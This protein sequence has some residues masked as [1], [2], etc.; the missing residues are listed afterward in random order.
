MHVESLPPALFPQF[1]SGPLSYH[2]QAIEAMQAM[3]AAAGFQAVRHIV[4]DVMNAALVGKGRYEAR[5]SL[6]PQSYVWAFAGTSD[7]AAGFKVQIVDL[8][9]KAE[10]FSQPIRWDNLTGQGATPEGLSFPLYIL[11]KPRLVLEPGLLSVQVTNL[12]AVANPIQLVVFTAE[13]VWKP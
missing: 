6:P 9:T 7:Q 4:P 5:I 12:A 11:P 13:P 3:R 10:W 8:G 1:R 2:A